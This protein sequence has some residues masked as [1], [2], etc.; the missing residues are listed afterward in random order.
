MKSSSLSKLEYQKGTL[1]VC[2]E[3]KLCS[4]GSK[5]LLQP[6]SFI[7]LFTDQS[8]YQK[9]NFCQKWS[10][11]QELK[12][13]SQGSKMLQILTNFIN[14]F[15]EHP[16]YDQFNFYQKW[17]CSREPPGY[18]AELKFSSQGSKIFSE[19]VVPLSINS[20]ITSS[21]RKSNFV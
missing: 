15:L 19:Y 8:F 21:M 2:V 12:F 4:Q 14:L 1:F 11:R 9:V 7:N 18:F 16:F 3:V 13:G 17:S 6:P 20:Q 10:C 5:M